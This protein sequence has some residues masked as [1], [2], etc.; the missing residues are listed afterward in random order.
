MIS[1][2]S[3]II[4]SQR[5]MIA[6]S[7]NS[8]IF[9]S[10]R[11]TYGYENSIICNSNSSSMLSVFEDGY[12]IVNSSNGVSIIASG[13]TCV[14]GSLHSS[15]I[16]GC[17]HDMRNT[18]GS[19]ILGGQENDVCDSTMSN[20]LG[21]SSNC[22]N[23][24]NFMSNI[25]GGYQNQIYGTSSLST[26]IGGSNNNICFNSIGSQII[27][28]DSNSICDSCGTTIIGGSNITLNGYCHVVVVPQLITGTISNPTFSTWKLGTAINEGSLILD[29]TKFI[30][31]EINGQTYKL[32]LATI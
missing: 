19:V 23:S 13:D 11:C 25:L 17:N 22:I 30:E 4:A 31:V 18:C 15:V 1:C 12:S 8:G 10:S 32:A 9:A 28:G 21:G 5:A 29:N 24:Y 27:G 14:Y 7:S 26:I 16:G 6:T 3:S 20:I 2:G